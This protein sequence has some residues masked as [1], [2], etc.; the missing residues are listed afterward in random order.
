MYGVQKQIAAAVIDFTQG[1]DGGQRSMLM[2][3]MRI[4]IWGRR[5]DNI[6]LECF[7]QIAKVVYQA[8]PSRAGFEMFRQ[9]GGIGTAEN[10]DIGR[11]DFGRFNLFFRILAHGGQCAVEVAQLQ[12][13]FRRHAGQKGN[14]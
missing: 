3:G 4:N 6:R 10:I 13:V 1:F 2:V 14:G 11:I 5:H 7:Y 9:W 12:D 8:V